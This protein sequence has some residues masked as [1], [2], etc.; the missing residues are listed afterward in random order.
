MKLLKLRYLQKYSL[1]SFNQSK[2]N[3]ATIITGKALFQARLLTDVSDFSV[4]LIQGV[5]YLVVYSIADSYNT[6]TPNFRLI[7]IDNV[8]ER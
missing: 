2:Y 4:H 8:S 7:Q 5:R 3:E 6:E 1:A